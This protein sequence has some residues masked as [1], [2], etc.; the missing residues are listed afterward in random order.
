MKFLKVCGN[1][2]LPKK[3]GDCGM[4]IGTPLNGHQI[5]IPPMDRVVIETDV[6]VALPKGSFGMMAERSSLA[7][8]GL[9]LSGCIID[10][11]YRGRVH[12]LAFN[13]ARET[14]ILQPGER[15]AQLIVVQYLTPSNHLEID[16]VKEE[17]FGITDTERKSSGMGSTGRV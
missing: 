15:I 1:I 8:R 2:S 16:R 4:D 5:E 10:E 13:S 14:M 6:R 17:D 11:G 12:L 9:I 7:K 3:A